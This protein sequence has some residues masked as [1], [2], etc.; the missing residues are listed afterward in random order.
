M[1]STI[2]NRKARHDYFLLEIFEAGLI[3]LG[4][5]VKSIREARVNLKDS[6]ARIIKGEVFLYN[7]HISPYSH[8]QA[9]EGIDPVR[10]RK[11]LLNREEIER[12]EVKCKSKGM[13]IVPTKLYFK[14][15]RVKVE[16][17]LGRGKQA[18]DKRETIRRRID[19]RESN[20]AIKSHQSRHRT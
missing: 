18:H 1:N 7:C 11:L 17:A 8:I 15:G 19:E 9:T 4:S 2:E 6:F 13:T 10:V 5:E 12:L 3:L 20:Q 16:I 14:K